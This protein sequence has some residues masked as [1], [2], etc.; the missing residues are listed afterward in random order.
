VSLWI[1]DTDHVSLVLRSNSRVI[2]HLGLVS[3]QTSTTIITVQE[4]LNG[5]VG[6]LN[7]PNARREAILDRYHHLFLAMELL[8]SLPIL[9]FDR[10]AF[11]RY[12][13]LLV[14]NPNLRK[15]RLQKDV[16]IAAIALSRNATVVTRNRRDC[17][18]VP[19]MKIED[20]TV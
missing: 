19:G 7:Q 3:T 1:L 6:E 18:Q 16:R 20:W 8:K 12:E 5:W 10:P 17:E 15:R 14:Q 11:D 2:A 13:A 4:I 9:E